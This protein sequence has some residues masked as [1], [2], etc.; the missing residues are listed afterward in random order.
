MSSYIAYV[1]DFSDSSDVFDLAYLERSNQHQLCE[2]SET[3][4]CE[5]LLNLVVTSNYSKISTLL[6]E[7]KSWVRS[8]VARIFLIGGFVNDY[9]ANTIRVP[10]DPRLKERNPERFSLSGDP[11]IQSDAER[12]A[13]SQILNS[14]EAIIWLPRDICL[15]RYA[16]HGILE[17]NLSC[18]A[19]RKQLAEAS[20]NDYDPVLLSSLPAFCLAAEPNPMPWLR[21]FRTIPAYVEA[22]P[23]GKITAFEP[24]AVTPNLYVV[25]GIDSLA[26]SKAMTAVLTNG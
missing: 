16:A 17:N 20:G 13:F 12:A 7:Q 15:W 18:Q 24:N 11:R 2:L 25:V 9:E 14:G 1:A 26:C 22:A 6:T 8:N 23:S 5:Q 21:Q 19:L 4:P 10:F 3:E